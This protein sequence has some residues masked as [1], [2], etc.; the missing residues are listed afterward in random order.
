MKTQETVVYNRLFICAFVVP[1]K[2]GIF[3][4]MSSLETHAVCNTYTHYTYIYRAHSSE[5][6]YTIYYTAKSVRHTLHSPYHPHAYVTF[7]TYFFF[8]FVLVSISY[9]ITLLEKVV[10]SVYIYAYFFIYVMMAYF[11]D[12]IFVLSIACHSR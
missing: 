9:K 12:L 3:P 8:F 4:R 7:A 5:S 1:Y 6:E 11:V 10:Y 2:R